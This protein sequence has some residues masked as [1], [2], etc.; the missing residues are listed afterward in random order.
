MPDLSPAAFSEVLSGDERPL[1]VGGQAV[2][3]WAE[4]YSPDVPELAGLGPF[5]SKDA[6]IYGTRELAL[7]IARRSGWDCE[8]IS[9]AN[10]T[11]AATLTKKP[12]LAGAEPL[13]VEVL[14]EVNGLTEQDLRIETSVQLE[15]GN[16]YRIPAPAV[17]LKAKLYNMVSLFI[18][19]RPQDLQ[20]TRMLMHVVPQRLNDLFS[21]TRDG[22]VSEENLFEAVEYTKRVVLAGFAENAARPYHLDFRAV[23]PRSL[24]FSGPAELRTSI[25]D[26]DARLDAIYGVDWGRPKTRPLPTPGQRLRGPEL[27]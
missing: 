25:A 12:S 2:N 21:K 14:G 19:E 1:I 16:E 13:V 18:R 27:G 10:S 26:A 9:D 23:F 17:L 4:L 7:S 8:I 6:D 24:R 20:Q 22:Q 5:T 15:D 3:I 11:L